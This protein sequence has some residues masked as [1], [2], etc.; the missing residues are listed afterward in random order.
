MGPCPVEVW[1]G[2]R[3]QIAIVLRYSV[4]CQHFQYQGHPCC[5]VHSPCCVQ[6]KVIWNKTQKR[7][8]LMWLVLFCCCEIG[9]SLPLSSLNPSRLT[10]PQQSLR[11]RPNN[12]CNTRPLLHCKL[13]Q[14]YRSSS[15]LLVVVCGRSSFLLLLLLLSFS[16]RARYSQSHPSTVDL[17]S[18]FA[19]VTVYITS[20][21]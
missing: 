16:E 11:R 18:V 14:A 13:G 17:L 9:S 2:S 1:W 5:S 10:S 6:W 21:C 19:F 4:P 3:R 7:I 15:F 8:F 12:E 20:F